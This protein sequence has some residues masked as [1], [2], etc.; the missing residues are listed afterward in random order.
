MLTET[1]ARASLGGAEPY[2]ELSV[3]PPGVWPWPHAG[4]FLSR[5]ERL[6]D[7]FHRWEQLVSLNLCRR[8][9]GSRRLDYRAISLKLAGPRAWLETRYYI[10]R[11]SQTGNAQLYADQRKFVASLMATDSRIS[12]HFGRLEPRSMHEPV[13]ELL[14]EGA[15]FG[16]EAQDGASV[17]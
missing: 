6:G 14:A 12:V 2:G 13:V 4:F 17:T 15:D 10:G 8:S 3:D 11:V 9:Q 16:H 7:D 1:P 5:H